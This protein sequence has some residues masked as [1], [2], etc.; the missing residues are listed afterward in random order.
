MTT[1]PGSWRIYEGST[2]SAPLAAALGAFVEQGYHG[3]SVR[4]IAGRA[5]LSVPGL[6]HHYPSKQALLVGLM[7]AAM[8]ELLARS[9]QADAEAGSSPSARF[10]AVVESLLLFHMY[11]S[12]QAFIGS[13][14]I[15]SL[16]PENRAHYVQLRDEQQRQLDGIVLAGIESG[17]FDAD[18]P[19]DASRAVTT[20]CVGVA[21]WYRPGGPL[22]ALELTEV[23][24]NIARR[25]VGGGR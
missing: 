18:H 11:R 20:M 1:T 16:D 6:Y 7:T 23:Y 24:L 17:E 12:D 13:T 14:E 19:A 5:G 8:D 9:K 22:S 25:I 3:T 10:D 21:G 15:R 4:Q 2:L